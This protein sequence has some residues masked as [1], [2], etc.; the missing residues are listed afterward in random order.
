MRR[1]AAPRARA[2]RRRGLLLE[3]RGRALAVRRPPRGLL[4]GLWELPGGELAA[5]EP[6][7]PALARA[8]R[9]RVGLGVAARRAARRGRARLHAPRAAPARLP[10]RGAARAASAARASTHTAGCRQPRSRRFRSAAP[11]ARRSRSCGVGAARLRSVDGVCGAGRP[12]RGCIFARVSSRF[13]HT[14]R[15]TTFGESHGGGVGVVVDGCPPRLPLDAAEIQRDLDRRRP[16]QSPLTTP[17]QEADRVEILSGVFEGRDAR[18]AD[19]A[20]RAQSGRAA[21]APTST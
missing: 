8:L 3:R 9:E 18:H 12:L 11:R 4:G 21:R 20:A 14:F 7:E 6:P 19:R 10:R 13:G 1:D 16:G 15:I 5:G 2:S 17:R